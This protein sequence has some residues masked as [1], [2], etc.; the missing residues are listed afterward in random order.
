MN[1]TYAKTGSKKTYALFR[2]T[3]GFVQ[4]FHVFRINVAR[5]KNVS[6]RLTV[7]VQEQSQ[8]IKSFELQEVV[9]QRIKKKII[10]IKLL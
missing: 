4:K 1:H 2:L 10:S 9:L 5:K 3:D 7:S 6:V 8:I